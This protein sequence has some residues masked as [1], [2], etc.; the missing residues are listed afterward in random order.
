M[1]HGGHANATA[2]L[3]LCGGRT[4]R[5]FFSAKC[6]PTVPSIHRTRAHITDL[7]LFVVFRAS[8]RHYAT[9][10]GYIQL[11]NRRLLF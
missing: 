6:H 7:A 8:D 1:F 4:E 10:F 2:L 9:A 11:V 5:G 3:H